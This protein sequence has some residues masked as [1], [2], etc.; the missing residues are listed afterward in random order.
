MDGSGNLRGMVLYYDDSTST[1]TLGQYDS[2][3]SSAGSF[4]L[5]GKRI[6]SMEAYRKTG[7]INYIMCGLKVSVRQVTIRC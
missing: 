6:S 1:A 4:T 7:S 5:S 3:C 2:G